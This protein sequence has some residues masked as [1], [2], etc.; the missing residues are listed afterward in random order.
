MTLEPLPFDI[1]REIV[2]I[3]ARSCLAQAAILAQVC[4]IFSDWVEPILLRI[5]NHYEDRSGWPLK[6]PSLSWF[7]RNGS[8]VIH[9]LWGIDERMDLLASILEHC[10]AL[11]NLGV[12]V[13]APTSKVHTI[14]PAL[15]KLRLRQLSIDIFALFST[16][17][18]GLEEA[19]DPMF[20][21]ITHLHAISQSPVDWRE[22]VG[23]AH[24]PSLTHVA[25]HTATM[26]AAE[27]V[28]DHCKSLEI[29]VV[30]D[31]YPRFS[32]RLDLFEKLVQIH[33]SDLYDWPWE[34]F[35]MGKPDFWN[36]AEGE[37]A[38][39]GN[40]RNGLERNA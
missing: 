17:T 25:L 32:P 12:W 34:G 24:L 20:N 10:P 21:H 6:S 4:K 14:R 26:D 22:V 27:G 3:S 37:V 9:L 38:S 5:V 11:E 33:L 15:S 35:A 39:R 36:T 29:L 1:L 31:L 19:S 7:Q 13:Y 18:F 2:E 40:S 8:Y 30:I 28:H 23:L 16:E